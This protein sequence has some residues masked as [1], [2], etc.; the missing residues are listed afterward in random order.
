[1]L[2]LASAQAIREQ[3]QKLPITLSYAEF[4]SAHEITPDELAQAMQW[5]QQLA[6]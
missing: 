1:M 4:P 6:A 5:L 3:V 2:P